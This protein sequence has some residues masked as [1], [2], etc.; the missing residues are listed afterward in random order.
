MK[1]S[2]PFTDPFEDN[3]GTNSF[4]RWLLWALNRIKLKLK[5]WKPPKA[6]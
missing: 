4:K 1:T 2:K 6:H 5:P 3:F